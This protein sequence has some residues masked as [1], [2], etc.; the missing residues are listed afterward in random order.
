MSFPI[1]EIHKYISMVKVL[2]RKYK[3]GQNSQLSIFVVLQTER[4]CSNG[5][6][7]T[8][9]S[10]PMVGGGMPA[11]NMSLSAGILYSGA[12]PTR[13]LHMLDIIKVGNLYSKYS[14]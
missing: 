13:S 1:S 5:H 11:G 8:W 9:I 2:F 3:I 12:S 14:T 7:H 10:Q 4:Q 6:F